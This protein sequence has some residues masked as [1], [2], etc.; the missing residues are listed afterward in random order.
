MRFEDLIGHTIRDISGAHERSKELLIETVEG[1][2]FKLYH[3]QDCC[4][5]VTLNEIIGSP[6][7][8]LIGHVIVVATETVHE[9]APDEVDESGTWTFYNLATVGGTVTLRWL[10][11]S[12]GYYSEAVECVEIDADG[13]EIY[14][15]VANSSERSITLVPFDPFLN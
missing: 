3:P 8:D 14:R 2:R 6:V 15:S 1:R 11:V 5:E 13:N 12:N 7:E 10:G 9:A 4:E